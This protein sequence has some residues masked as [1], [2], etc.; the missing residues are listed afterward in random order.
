M[1]RLLLMLTA[2]AAL[3]FFVTL[4]AS[5]RSVL[6]SAQT[7]YWSAVLVVLAS[8]ESYRRMVRSR[9]EAGAVPDTGADRDVIDKLEDP[10][11]LYAEDE[12]EKPGEEKSLR[13]T[14]R[15]EKARMKKNRRSPLATARDA[16]PA[17]SL[18]RLGAYGVLVLGFFF[19][20]DQKLLHLG[21]YLPSLGLPI[22][23]TVWYLM[24]TE[25]RRAA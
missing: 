15:E 9:L 10:F 2:G 22:V 13:E 12:E 8:F 7:G 5:D 6:F 19:L 1:R 20:R 17:F 25:R 3:L 24:G 16:V 23:L 11:D 21:A 18:W 4:L 14:I